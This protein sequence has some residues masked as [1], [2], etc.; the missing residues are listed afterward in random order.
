MSDNKNTTV[1]E[2]TKLLD[3]LFPLHFA[4]VSEDVGLIIG[5]LDARIDKII[6][7]VDFCEDVT[8]SAIKHNAELVLTFHSPIDAP[9][10]RITGKTAIG[11]QLL[12]LIK[13]GI[14]LYSLGSA[15]D[16]M[17]GGLADL[18]LRA[19]DCS[20]L[21][22]LRP[23]ETER[24]SKVVADI[25]ASSI[26]SAISAALKAA[27]DEQIAVSVRTG[28]LNFEDAYVFSEN[29][30]PEIVAKLENR[31]REKIRIEFVCKKM[32]AAKIVTNLE[33]F[34]K[35]KLD[36]VNIV[37]L[38]DADKKSGIGRVGELPKKNS[39]NEIVAKLKTMLRTQNLRVVASDNDSIKR[40]AIVPSKAENELLKQAR[41]YG[42][43][44]LIVS[45]LNSQ[46]ARFARNLGLS[47]VE[48]GDFALRMFALEKIKEILL[49]Q[50]PAFEII[51]SVDNCGRINWA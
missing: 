33:Q 18:V 12:R 7:A 35:D 31:E 2:I 36:N 47:L 25:E 10:R 44:C 11:R 21:R 34:L 49:K 16:N 48:T 5:Q 28:S 42:A 23:L 14:A 46:A 1:S 45:E 19:F 20:K 24:F 27:P 26:A 43:R 15:F 40:I 3:K 41:N 37:G 30:N 38:E 6:L 39:L 8:N 32:L 4:Q 22:V 51:I 50:Q 9:I 29:A 17:Q 13:N